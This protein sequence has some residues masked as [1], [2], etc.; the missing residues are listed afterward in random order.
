VKSKFHP[1]RSAAIVVA[2]LVTSCGA[3]GL[4]RQ[5]QFAWAIGGVGSTSPPIVRV[6]LKNARDDTG[7]IRCMFSDTLIDAIQ[8]EEGL[9]STQEG[10]ERAISFALAPRDHSFRFVRPESWKV[11][12]AR[13]RGYTGIELRRGCAMIEEGKSALW[14]D[15]QA[16][17]VEG[18]HFPM[19]NGT[20]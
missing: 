6:R 11:I 5:D 13:S 12:A 16:R 19:K 1:S 14:A 10:Y 2:V 17:V 4:Q 7:S 9:P 3:G 18:P 8:L 15:I 20:R